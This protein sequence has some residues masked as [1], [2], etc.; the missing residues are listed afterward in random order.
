MQ[1]LETCC[2]VSYPTI[3]QFSLIKPPTNYRLSQTEIPHPSSFCH[4]CIVLS[5]RTVPCS[6]VITRGGA[7]MAAAADEIPASALSNTS[8]SSILSLSL[9]SPSLHCRLS[10]GVGLDYDGVHRPDNNNGADNGGEAEDGVHSPPYPSVSFLSYKYFTT[11]IN[12]KRL[13]SAAAC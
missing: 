1:E 7:A 6:G 5:Y 11:W 3:S 12:I 4:I 8:P 13:G 2:R 9:P 10:L